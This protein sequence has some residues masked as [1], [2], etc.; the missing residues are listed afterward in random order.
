MQSIAKYLLPML[1][2]PLQYRDD[3]I[4]TR[5]V[6]VWVGGWACVR[7]GGWVWGCVR[8]RAASY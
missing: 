1:E 7:V 5:C 4:D 8:A 2:C 3:A 6:C